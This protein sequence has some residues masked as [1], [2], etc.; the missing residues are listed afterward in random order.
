MQSLIFYV[1][2]SHADAVKQAVF[3]A[4]G[5]EVGYYSHCSWQT[6][7]TGQF[8]PGENSDPKLGTV[9]QISQV[10]EMRVEILVNDSLQEACE[11]ALKLSHPYETPVYYFLSIGNV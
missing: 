11:A 5:G 4:G 2:V 10:E 8:V 1:P 9:G 3:D 7:G 6:T